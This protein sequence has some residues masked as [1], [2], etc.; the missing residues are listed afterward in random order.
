MKTVWKKGLEKDAAEEIELA[1]N[2]GGVLRQRL[3][4]ILLERIEVADRRSVSEEGYDC[5]NW[6]Y[7][8]AD[9]SGYKRALFEIISLI[10]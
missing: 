2:S 7:K 9:T 10:E 1:F 8:Q 5:P 6:A 4:E 3:R